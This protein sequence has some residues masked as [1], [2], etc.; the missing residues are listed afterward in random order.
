[1]GA[2]W[3]GILGLFFGS[4]FAFIPRTGPL[5]MTGPIVSWIF[6]GLAGAMVVGGL[7]ALGA[8]IYNLGTSHDS[9]LQSE[10]AFNSGKFAFAVS[11][12]TEQ[13]IFARNIIKHST[14]K[15]LG[16]DPIV[17]TSRKCA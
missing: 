15:V 14:A 2:V 11:D 12:S 10:T 16:E 4:A 9:I 1:M 8:G 3:G 5:L 17:C 7:G 13:A 6:L